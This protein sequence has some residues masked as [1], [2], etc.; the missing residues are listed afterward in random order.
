MGVLSE[1]RYARTAGGVHIAQQVVDAG[2]LDIP[3]VGDGRSHVGAIRKIA[4]GAQLNTFLASFSRLIRFDRLGTGLSDPVPLPQ[5]PS[6][7]LGEIGPGA[8]PYPPD[9]CWAKP[10]LDAGADAMRH[11]YDYPDVAMGLGRRAR[12]SGTAH[13]RRAAAAAF[14]E[15]VAASTGAGADR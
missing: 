13:T 14:G 7:E 12:A 9:A 8:E 6:L 1:T 2:P 4:V 10:D 5:I 15:R 11:L 3:L